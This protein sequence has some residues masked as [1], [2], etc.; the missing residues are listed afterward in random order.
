MGKSSTSFK[1]GNKLWMFRTMPAGPKK[2]YESAEQ[3]WSAAVNYFEWV[4]DNPLQAHKAFCYRNKITIA[5]INKPRPMH[6]AGFCA[7]LN[8]SR[9][10]WYNY[11]SSSKPDILHI[12]GMI[13]NVI[14]D[15]QITGT[16]VGI[17]KPNIIARQ[18]SSIS[19]LL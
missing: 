19:R 10:T 17:F 16:L 4:E 5:T 18:L 15:Q 9:R 1:K 3:L 7:H 12:T 14:I 2:K 8:I 6:I 13:E 11:K